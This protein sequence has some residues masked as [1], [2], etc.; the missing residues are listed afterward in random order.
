M[1]AR[2]H[3]M[4]V[5]DAYDLFKAYQDPT[6][7]YADEGPYAERDAWMAV[8]SHLVMQAECRGVES[9]DRQYEAEGK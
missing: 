1:T 6:S 7:P 9:C 8:V 2:L 3:G 5:A 4:S